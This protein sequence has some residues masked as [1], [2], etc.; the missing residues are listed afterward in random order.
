MSDDTEDPGARAEGLA[1]ELA[2]WRRELSGG[3]SFDSFIRRRLDP[4][5]RR[6]ECFPFVGELVELGRQRFRDTTLRVLD[7][8]SGPLSTVAWIAEEGLGEVVA[9]D[10]LGD[11]YAA[12]LAELGIDFPVVPRAGAGETL[13]ELFEP[14]SFHLVYSRNALDHAAEPQRCLDE[15]ERVL[16]P[17]GALSLELFAFEGARQAYDG[18]HRFDFLTRAGELVCEDR[19]GKAC[20]VVDRERFAVERLE[21]S[22][23]GAWDPAAPE[24]A[25]HVC[26]VKR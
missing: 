10:P 8:G 20:L 2:Y 21:P 1:E 14:E 24:T 7:V 9:V 13:R 19:E 25:I 22:D 17:G 5:T 26:L 6:S 23:T 16:V 12:L 4:A 15:I 11:E 3:G 18:L